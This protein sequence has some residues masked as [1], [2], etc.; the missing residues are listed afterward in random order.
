MQGRGE[1]LATIAELAGAKV[2]NVR[3][4]LKAAGAQSATRSGALGDASGTPPS[5]ADGGAGNGSAVN[6]AEAL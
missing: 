4:V 6:G 5:A 2:G 1:T 3:T